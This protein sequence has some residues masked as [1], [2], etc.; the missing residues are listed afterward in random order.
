MTV[1]IVMVNSLPFEEKAEMK[2]RRERCSITIACHSY[3]SL[4]M[5]L[6]RF[7]SFTS[8]CV[9]VIFMACLFCLHDSFHSKDDD[10]ALQDEIMQ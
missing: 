2:Q 1:M 6:H 7:V 4:E 3:S 9:T 5:K 8:E 10:D